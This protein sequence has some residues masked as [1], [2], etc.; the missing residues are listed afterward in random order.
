M[1]FDIGSNGTVPE[2]P[3]ATRSASTLSHVAQRRGRS[4]EIK[5]RWQRVGRGQP[6]NRGEGASKQLLRIICG[7]IR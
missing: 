6:G 1:N 2:L 5:N 7:V 3:A 4:K